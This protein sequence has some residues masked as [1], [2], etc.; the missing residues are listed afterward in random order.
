M[1]KECSPVS[2]LFGIRQCI[3]VFMVQVLIAFFFGFELLSL[4]GFNI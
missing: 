2:L 1:T 3:F 4:D